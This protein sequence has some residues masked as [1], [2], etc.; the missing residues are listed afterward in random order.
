MI[1]N[2]S[3]SK[4]VCTVWFLNTGKP[5]AHAT[6]PDYVPSLFSYVKRA[7]RREDR[8]DRRRY[9]LMREKEHQEQEDKHKQEEEK[10]KM[11]DLIMKQ[12]K[13]DEEQNRAEQ[14]QREL[15]EAENR[16]LEA[17]HSLLEFSVQEFTK[18]Q[19]TQVE[20]TLA[21]TDSGNKGEVCFGVSAIKGDDKATKFYTGLEKY[22][23]HRYTILQGPL[24]VC[25]LKHKGDLDVANIDKILV[26]CS[27]L[28]NLS[29]SIVA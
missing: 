5:S 29:K 10:R 1:L 7:E 12:Q 14:I 15:K 24:P 4:T 22:S 3:V 9:R 23:I 8:F 2:D 26:V 18:D 19:S 21:M 13:A 11:K 28:I 6:H 20:V 25:L 16:R 27:S 17:A